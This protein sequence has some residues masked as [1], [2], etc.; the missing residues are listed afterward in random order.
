[1]SEQRPRVGS[2]GQTLREDRKGKYYSSYNSL[3]KFFQIL[4]VNLIFVSFPISFKMLLDS[5]KGKDFTKK[6]AN[7]TNPRTTMLRQSRPFVKLASMKMR[8]LP[9]NASTSFQK[10][11][12]EERELLNLDLL[13]LLSGFATN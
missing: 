8:L 7:A 5:S 6:Q 12:T 3:C 4:A 1:M 11:A 2:F 13:K 10:V 9:L